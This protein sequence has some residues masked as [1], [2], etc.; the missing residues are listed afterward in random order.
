MHDF[1]M[2]QG[3]VKVLLGKEKKLATITDDDWDEMDVRALSSICPC[4]ANNVLFNIVS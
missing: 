1:L 2:Q 4:L 3:M